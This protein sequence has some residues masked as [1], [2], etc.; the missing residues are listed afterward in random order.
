MFI[1][2]DAGYCVLQINHSSF[3]K[4]FGGKASDGKNEPK[5]KPF[6]KLWNNG[7]CAADHDRTW[8]SKRFGNGW[9]NNNNNNGNGSKTK[10][11]NGGFRGG[12]SRSNVTTTN[13]NGNGLGRWSGSAGA[14]IK[15]IGICHVCPA[16]S[17]RKH[18]AGF[19]TSAA[20][21][22]S[23]ARHFPTAIFGSKKANE[24]NKEETNAKDKK[25]KKNVEEQKKKEEISA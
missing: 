9:T 11:F 16:H 13:N 19:A 10:F 7:G 25:K 24:A 14:G 20:K 23:T 4:P 1:E 18:P 5:Q 12:V 17:P 8:S 22:P 2:S 15:D 21:G 6:T 3:R